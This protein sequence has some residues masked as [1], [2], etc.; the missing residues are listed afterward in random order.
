MDPRGKPL[1]LDLLDP[2]TWERF[3]WGPFNPHASERSVAGEK[4][5]LAAALARARAFH[6][7][8]ARMPDHAAPVPVHA[9]GGDCLPT[10]TRAV[11]GKGPPGSSP[12]FEARNAR[13]Q[14]VLYEAGDGRVTRA[15][16]LAA[17]LAEAD[18]DPDASG[19]PEL[20]GAFFG[21]ADHHGL[22]ADPAFQSLL[23]R[24]LR[25]PAPLALARPA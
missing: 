17:H 25:R 5:F 1:D 15:S 11:A 22:F 7:G 6:A 9:L 8:L 24:L 20:S 18:A 14:E 3:G 21:S 4:S 19:I 12:R 2:A 10:L 13:E 16:F 23:L